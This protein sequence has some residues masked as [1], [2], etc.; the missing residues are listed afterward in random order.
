M[1]MEDLEGLTGL[2]RTK[3]GSNDT[4]PA[5]IISRRHCWRW[6]ACFGLSLLVLGLSVWR[7][8]A[9]L[10]RVSPRLAAR[11]AELRQKQHSAHARFTKL[12]Q[13]LEQHLETDMHERDVAM[14][15]RARLRALEKTH[16]ANVTRALEAAA[17]GSEAFGLEAREA[18]RP[19]VDA[20]I[21]SL[22][23]EL[24][25]VVEGRILSPMMAS[26][27]AAYE[28][29]KA[30]H[31]EVL[32]ELKRDREEREAFLR[33][34]HNLAG[35]ADGDGFVR[36][37][38]VDEFDE[39]DAERRDEEWRRDVVANFF[40]SFQRHFNDTELQMDGLPPRALLLDDSDLFRTLVDLRDQLGSSQFY[41]PSSNQSAAS[42]SWRQA[43][44]RLA[45]LEP[46]LD[47]HRCPRFVPSE[48]PAD[49]EFDYMQLHNVE[50]YLSD[51]IWHAKLNAKRAEIQHLLDDYKAGVV[52]SMSLL[53]N[54]EQFEGDG[55]FPSYWLF[56]TAGPYDD[57]R[58]ADW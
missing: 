18:V 36:D 11:R 57:Y 3:G 21:D 55:V 53:E 48:P 49:D 1:D 8:D 56:H 27:S 45:D 33:K 42:L 7:S 44:A 2:K 38:W 26:S 29:H 22:F 30:L 13:E 20:A 51:M 43:E 50:R 34:K 54:L 23:E 16:R 14:K 32:D 24:R 31:Y 9:M 47:R 10:R 15:L 6:V 17:L 4:E 28:R 35:D 52:P 40:D 39:E 12:G 46:E 5:Y 58:Y 25:Y 19:Y 37:R 41:E